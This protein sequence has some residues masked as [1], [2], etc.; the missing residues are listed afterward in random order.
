MSRLDCPSP[1]RLSAFVLGK[2][3]A[4]ELTA[5]AEHLDVCPECEEKT[6]ELDGMADA[7][8]CELRQIP[9]SH[10][11]TDH[12]ETGPNAVEEAASAAATESWGEFRIVRELGRGGMGV[13]CE[14]FQGSLNR[15]VALKFLPERG[16][17]A[18]FRREARAAGR[19]HHTNIVPVF[20]VGEHQGRH[21]Y[22]M[23]FIAGRGLDAVLDRARPDRRRT[24]WLRATARPPGSACRSPR[25][26]PTPTPR[27]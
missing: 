4:P 24:G 14:A 26:W 8:V 13:V 12:V 23:Q 10:P 1:D 11:V 2:L 9:S 5:V 22:V 3:P 18:R 27:A 19:L 25:R 7:V 15:H 17:L 20:G 6:A 21:F 16:D